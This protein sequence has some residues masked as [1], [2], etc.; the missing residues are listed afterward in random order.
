MSLEEDEAKWD[1]IY[2]VVEDERTNHTDMVSLFLMLRDEA[3]KGSNPSTDEKQTSVFSNRSKKAKHKS[4]DQK[5]TPESPERTGLE[6]RSQMRQRLKDGVS[7]SDGYGLLIKGTLENPIEVA[8]RAGPLSHSEI[9]EPMKDIVEIKHLM[10]CRLLL[11][12]ASLLPI[13]IRANSA[14]EFLEGKEISNTD[15]RDL[16]LKMENPGLQEVRDACADLVRG[17][18]ENDTKPED[19]NDDKPDE[20]QVKGCL[21]APTWRCP[22][23]LPQLWI[24]KCDKQEQKSASIDVKFLMEASVDLKVHSLTLNRLKTRPSTA[25]KR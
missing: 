7:Y 23:G 5:P 14:E 21:F 3:V 24:S 16:C 18:E 22:S 11:S 15:L 9:D 12:H 6:T 1:P 25:A 20:K 13:A 4:S 2:D 17:G 10:F 8:D 19:A